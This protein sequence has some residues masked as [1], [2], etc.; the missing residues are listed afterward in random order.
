MSK[1]RNK[2]R[3]TKTDVNTICAM[4][5]KIDAYESYIMALA[6]G[7]SPNKDIKQL[8]VIIIGTDM[9]DWVSMA[10]NNIRKMK[11]ELAELRQY[12][13]NNETPK[14]ECLIK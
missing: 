12:K 4:Q 6:G 9:D 8:A 13:E 3:F 5:R 2:S 1:R 10:W 7:T 11:D 14:K